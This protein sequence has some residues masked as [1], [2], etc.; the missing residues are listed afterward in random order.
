MKL[1][2]NT[3]AGRLFLGFSVVLALSIGVNIFAIFQFQQVQ[4]VS[5]QISEVWMPSVYNLVQISENLEKYST[6]AQQHIV[7]FDRDEKGVKEDEM[8][9]YKRKIEDDTKAYKM[10]LDWRYAYYETLIKERDKGFPPL[11]Y[12]DSLQ[13]GY[14]DLERFAGDNKVTLE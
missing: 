2:L 10:L 8:K 6:A 1:Q 11:S 7:T 14:I 12:A 4:R 3:L 9:D 5:A 13:S